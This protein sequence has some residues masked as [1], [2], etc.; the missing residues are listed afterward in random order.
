MNKTLTIIVVALAA[1]GFWWWQMKGGVVEKVEA[2]DITWEFEEV[3]TDEET[4]APETRVIMKVEGDSTDLGTY[5][6]SCSE[7][8]GSSWSLVEGEV[9]GVICW[10]AGGGTEI[11][12]FEEANGS[13]VVKKGVLDEGSAEEP[14][15]RGGFSLMFKL[16]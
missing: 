10:F 16:N 5:E 13:L 8:K 14:G 4:G 12:V 9:S 2:N 7:I 15:M 3:G 1:L 6:G 11:G